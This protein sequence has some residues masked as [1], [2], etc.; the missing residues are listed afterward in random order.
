MKPYPIDTKDMEMEDK[1]NNGLDFHEFPYLGKSQN[2]KPLTTQRDLA[3]IHLT[4]TLLVEI[5]ADP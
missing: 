5:A 3:L 4:G 2:N 1:L